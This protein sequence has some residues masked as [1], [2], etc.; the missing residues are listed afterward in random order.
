MLINCPIL[1]P[2]RLWYGANITSPILGYEYKLI[3]RFSKLGLD[4]I[5]GRKEEGVDKIKKKIEKK[6]ISL[7]I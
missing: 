3:H 6:K 5:R 4:I 1:L 7:I 2:F